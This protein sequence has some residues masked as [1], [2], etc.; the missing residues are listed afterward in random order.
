MTEFDDDSI[1]EVEIGSKKV[2]YLWWAVAAIVLIGL[3]VWYAMIITRRNRVAEALAGIDV[4][5]NQRHDLIPNVLKIAR[6]FMEHEKGLL[7]EITT[8]RASAASQAGKRDLKGAA[9]RFAVESKLEAG[10]GRLFALAEN[11]PA[12]KSDG[13]MIE[14]QRAYS[15]IETN[16]AAARRFYNSAVGDLRNIT[17]V[18]PGRVLAALAG[19]STRPPFFEAPE[20]ARAP[21]DA[22]AYL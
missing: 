12:L 2:S 21:V 16:I 4:Q 14:A 3:Y 18:F 15:E 5:L 7:E 9:E 13:P 17:Q 22:A 11:Y 20:A 10:I 6:R 1:Q 8:L 19:V